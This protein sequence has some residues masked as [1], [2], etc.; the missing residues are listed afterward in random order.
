MFICLLLGTILLAAFILL[1]LA[2]G[3][4]AANAL[5]GSV[6]AAEVENYKTA[7]IE[8]NLI[9]AKIEHLQSNSAL[10]REIDPKLIKR[11]KKL[12]KKAVEIKKRGTS[13]KKN[14]LSVL[15]LPPL[16][17]YTLM[18]ILKI[19]KTKAFYANLEAKCQQFKEKRDAARHTDYLIANLFGYIMLGVALMFI[20]FGLGFA[21]GLGNRALV[22]GVVMLVATALLGYLP[23][24]A[25]S[26]VVNKRAEDIE[27]ALPRVASKLTLLTLAGIDVMKAWRLTAESETTT[28]Y[29]EMQRV[30]LELDNGVEHAEAFNNF[31]TRCANNYTTKLAT[32][33][34]QNFTMGPN[35]IAKLFRELNTESWSE[36][37][38]IARRKGELISGKLLIP[39]M[40]LFVGIIILVTVPALGGF[41]L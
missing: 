2:A 23:Y 4:S 38:H 36:Y 16:A 13:Y 34:M 31:I 24:D 5:L 9:K 33:I 10:R 8:Y 1:F 20:G 15:E 12:E 25:V 29:S 37:R 26:A 6:Y 11:M 22:V 27:Y 40:L 18:R 32:A 30:N 41:N 3:D 7:E 21:L 39:T 17:G 35:E 14:G 19:D 28:L